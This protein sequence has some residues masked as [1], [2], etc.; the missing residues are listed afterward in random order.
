MTRI[1]PYYALVLETANYNRRMNSL[2][3]RFNEDSAFVIWAE[4][5]TASKYDK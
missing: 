3:T 2:V 5:F 1:H 4:T